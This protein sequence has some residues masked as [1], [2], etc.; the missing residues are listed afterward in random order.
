MSKLN[1]WFITFISRKKITHYND[2]IQGLD[3]QLN[4]GEDGSGFGDDSGNISGRANGD[5]SVQYMLLQDGGFGNGSGGLNGSGAGD[6]LGDGGGG[7]NGRSVT[8]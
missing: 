6:G 7:T 1:N 5:V 8:G 2:Y 3:L 4:G